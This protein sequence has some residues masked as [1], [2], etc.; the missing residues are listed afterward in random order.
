M[1][2][3]NVPRVDLGSSL[4]FLDVVRRCDVLPA[5]RVEEIRDRVRKG[6]YPPDALA[7][8]A[9]LVKKGVLTGYQAR[10]LLH[11]QG[12]GLAVDRYILLDRL[13][14]GAM[15]KVYKA[16]HRFMGRIV[17][18]KFI[19]REYLARP[20]AL[21]RF[22]RE[23]RVVGRLDHPQHRPRPRC[24]AD[25]SR[26]RA[27]S[28]SMCPDRTSSISSLPAARFRPVTSRGGRWRR[29]WGWRMPTSRV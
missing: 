14:R 22:L 23:M 21:P 28:W 19:T 6:S 3:A 16:R 15:G 1:N 2:T 17:A 11:G 29:H 4:D 7:L 8:A 18:L 5:Q 9:R 12:E 13:G 26:P 24:R 27:S 25:R 20:N 10:R